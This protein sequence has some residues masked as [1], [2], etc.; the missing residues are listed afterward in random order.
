M[1]YPIITTDRSFSKD[2]YEVKF[3]LEGNQVMS[4]LLFR[5]KQIKCKVKEYSMISLYSFS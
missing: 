4:G 2:V 1:N 3:R 5:H